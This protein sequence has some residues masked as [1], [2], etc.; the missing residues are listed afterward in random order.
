MANCYRDLRTRTLFSNALP[1]PFGSRPQEDIASSSRESLRG[2]QNI[3]GTS[4]SALSKDDTPL[5]STSYA[6]SDVA[7][8]STSAAVV[9]HSVPHTK[10]EELMK[11][12]S[13]KKDQIRKLKFLCKQRGRTIKDL[14]KFNIHNNKIV[15][16]IFKGNYKKICMLM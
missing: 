13:R 3:R 11:V 8:P 5:P 14:S 7:I 1:S 12:V 2:I 15:K 6:T 4:T 10:K 16:D 9:T